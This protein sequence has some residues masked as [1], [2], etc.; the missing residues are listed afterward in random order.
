MI[1]T[2]TES[3][4]DVEDGIVWSRKEKGGQDSR[5]N[6]NDLVADNDS[7]SPFNLDILIIIPI[8]KT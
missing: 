1:R 7:V 3:Q 2:R 4:K 6:T 5:Y 8:F